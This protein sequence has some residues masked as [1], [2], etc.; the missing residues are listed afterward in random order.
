MSSGALA[1]LV[2]SEALYVRAVVV[3]R[4]RG[5]RVGWGQIAA[6]H[7]G[8]ALQG[9]ALVGPLDSGAQDHLSAHMAQHLLLADIAVPFLLAGV[10]TPVLVFLLPRPALVVLARRRGLRRA[11]RFL[12]RPL[13]AVPVY[14]LVLYAWH[15]G[16]AFEAALR[17]PVVHALQHVSFVGIGVLVW[18][19]ALEPQR[20]RLRGELWKIPY[21]FATRMVSMFLGMAL[22]FSHSPWYG[23]FYGSHTLRDQQTAG[24]IMMSVDIVIMVAALAYFFWRASS[25]NDLVEAAERAEAEAARATA[26]T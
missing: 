22:V 9:L 1:L 23:D 10:R 26:A 2:L 5:W 6:W 14:V 7:L 24:G 15:L 8:W 19:S 11:F 20:A 12:R 25:D 21:V 18:W 17:H 4:R 16:F 3:L 13:V